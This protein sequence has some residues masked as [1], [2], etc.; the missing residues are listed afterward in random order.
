MKRTADPDGIS[1]R[2]CPQCGGLFLVWSIPDW[3]YVING[4][5]VCSWHCLR[6]VERGVKPH[7]SPE[8]Q[9]RMLSDRA[10]R[11]RKTSAEKARA[12]AVEIIRLRREGLT[13][14]QIADCLGLTYSLVA[15]RVRQFSAEL[16]FTGMTLAE[17]GRIGGKNNSKKRRTGGE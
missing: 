9:E 2:Y 6:E 14:H 17:A 10:E 7:I 3:A 8:L 1:E 15:N 5:L 11:A 13:N 16:G 12:Q 4:R